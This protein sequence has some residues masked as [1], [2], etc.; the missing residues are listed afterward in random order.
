M[1]SFVTFGLAA[2]SGGLVG[3]VLGLVGGGGSIL[4]VPLLT[5]AVGVNSPH[6]AIGTSAL[7]V[8]VS[9]AGNLVPQW[10]A[11]NVKWRCAGAFS[12]AGVLGA[13][14][15]SAAARAVDGQSLLALFGFVMLAVGGLMLRRRRGEGDPDVRLTK[16][17]APV[18]LPWLLGIGFAV[19]LF[20]GFFGIGGGFLI[21]PGLMLATSMPLPMAIG[22]SLVA[23][24]AFGAATAAS[25]AVSGLIDWTLAGLFI[26]GGALGGLVG[27][28]LGQRLAGHKRALTITFAGLVILVGLYV[29]AR[30]LPALL[31][32]A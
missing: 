27:A 28:R 18:L 13:L 14:A 24:S 7:A 8:S 29:V 20:S 12:L 9:A 10:R 30:G 4:A 2:G 15:G 11:G 22:T 32:R 31:G 25:Y 6:V 26:L 19:G 3:V 21:V 1:A 16:R 23:V 17:S 5:Y